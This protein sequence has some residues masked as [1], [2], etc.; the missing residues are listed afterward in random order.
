MNWFPDYNH[1]GAH[2]VM[3]L[4]TRGAAALVFMMMLAAA[5]AEAQ[6]AAAD[7]AWARGDY[8]AA[9]AGYES[10][11]LTQPQSVRANYRLGILA[12]WDGK[13]DSALVLIRRARAVEP[14]DPDLELTEARVLAWKGA[15]D[16]ALVHY[17]NILLKRPEHREALLSRAQTLAW[18]N[19]FDA[20]DAAYQDM[21]NRDPQNLD[22]RAG[23]AQLAAWR[24]DLSG[25]IR[26]YEAILARNPANAEALAGL[27][28]VYLWQGK[29][30]A[31]R[32]RSRRAIA[33]DPANRAAR[34]LSLAVEAE[35][36]TQSEVTL[37]W[38]NDSDDNTSWWQT[39][40][41]SRRLTD[42]FRVFGSVGALEVSD[43]L[44]NGSRLSAEAGASYGFGNGQ[45][46]G[47]LGVRRLSPDS[48]PSRTALT[49]RTSAGYRITP[50]IGAGIAFAHYPF[51]ETALL[52]EQDITIDALDLTLDYQVRPGLLVNAGAGQVWYSDHNSRTF[53]LLAITQTIHRDFFVGAMV[54]GLSYEF[55]GVG[56]F[57]PDRFT[58]GEARA[59]WSRGWSQWHA[60]LSGGL[61]VQQVSRGTR[62]QAE[63]HLEGRLSRNWT[64]FNVVEVFAGLTNS[65]ESSTTG[66]FR[67]RTAG[68]VILIAL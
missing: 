62:S 61:G 28:Q 25:A 10:V 36:R 35:T 23:R 12:S 65:A 5:P 40:A 21:L 30:A 45:V 14:E 26:Q 19:R 13:L 22:A 63:W 43:P 39:V 48:A 42:A 49:F 17:D 29:T 66:A 3:R 58:L 68:I 59:G 38:S 67:Y 33:A 52:L 47:A 6:Q 15:F 4:A 55:K 18:A 9:R 7:S 37:G 51:D 41:A 57:S 2:Q 1:S 44:R 11:L 50:A 31:A 53:G 16:E 46:T 24:G 27:G 8:P 20:A 60:R 56:Y 64:R 32:E 54:R 34:E